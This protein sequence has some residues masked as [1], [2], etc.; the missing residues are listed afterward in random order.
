MQQQLKRDDHGVVTLV[1]VI[2]MSMLLAGAGLIFV[3]A[4]QRPV[5]RDAQG[6]ADAGAIAAALDCAKGACSGGAASAYVGGNVILQS[7]TCGSTSCTTTM[8]QNGNFKFVVSAPPVTASAT[9]TWGTLSSFTDIFPLTVGTC[10]IN[11]LTAGQLVTLHARNFGGC[12]NGPGQFGWLDINCSAPSRIDTSA[13]VDGTPGNTPKSCSNAQLDGFLS[14]DVF[15]PIFDP[16]KTCGAHTYCITEFAQLHLTG[17]SGNGAANF[18]CNNQPGGGGN[19][20]C[21][22]G[23]GPSSVGKQCDASLD[24]QGDIN[25]AENTPCIRGYFIKPVKVEE[26]GQFQPGTCNTSGLFICRVYLTK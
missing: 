6:R 17:W 11:G 2:A 3:A 14:T 19:R 12:L 1:V 7:S 24:G 26:V 4:N 10:A 18:G 9:A 23:H 5:R 20:Q 22:A 15:V 21:P 16:T 13:G 25:Y 8:Q